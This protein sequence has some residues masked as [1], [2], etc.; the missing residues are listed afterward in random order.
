MA[1]PFLSEIRMFGGNYAPR[2]W[3]LC[4]GQLMSIAQNTAL[5][6]LLGTNFGGDGRVTFGLPNLQGSAPLMAGNG[7]GLTPRDLGEVGGEPSVTLLSSQMAQHNH[8][9]LGTGQPGTTPDPT[10]AVWAVAGVA[11]G[12]N[13]YSSNP[14]SSPPMNA[15]AFAPSGG[16]QPHNNMPPYLVVSFII[17][18]QGI[19]PQRP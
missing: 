15:Q 19:F 10:G 7:P 8:A 6:S 3:A 9:A 1:D 5:F 4:Q 12:T 17:C 11:R 13:M 18:L 2:S 16:S 14:G